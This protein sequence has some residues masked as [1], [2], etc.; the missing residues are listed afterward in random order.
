MRR[1]VDRIL[2]ADFEFVPVGQLA[3]DATTRPNGGRKTDD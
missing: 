2:A 1:A 3:A